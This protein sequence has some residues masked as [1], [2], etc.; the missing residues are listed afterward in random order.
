MSQQQ[1]VPGGKQSLPAWGV[2]IEIKFNSKTLRPIMSLPAW[3]VWIEMSKSPAGNLAVQSLP[4]WGVWIE[5]GVF[6]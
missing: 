4:A 2:W 5:I 6:L 3:G 1:E